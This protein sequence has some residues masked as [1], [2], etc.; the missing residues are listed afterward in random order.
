MSDETLKPS[1]RYLKGMEGF[2]TWRTGQPLIVAVFQELE[3]QIADLQRASP[4]WRPS[5]RAERP[6][7]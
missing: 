4:N 5:E 3:Q 6:T 2:E 1:E 7:A